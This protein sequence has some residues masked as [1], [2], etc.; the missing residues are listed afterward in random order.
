MS[1]NLIDLVTSTLGKQVMGQVGQILGEETKATESAIGAAIPAILGG[2]LKKASTPEGANDVFRSLDDEDGSILDNLGGLIGGGQHESLIEKGMVLLKMLFGSQQNSIIGAIAKAAGI[3]NSSAGSILGM[4]AP[5]VMG[6]LGKQRQSSGLDVGGLTDLLFSQKDHLA[7][8]MPK[9][10]TS[11]LGIANLLDSGADAVAGTVDSARR[12]AGRAASEAADTAQAAGGGL[13]KLLIPLLL[14]LGLAWL[15][16]KYFGPG[17]VDE[18]DLPTAEAGLQQLDAI[19]GDLT[20]TFDGLTESIQ[21]IT[22][23][24][25]ARSAVSKIEEATSTLDSLKLDSLPAAGATGLG[26]VLNPLIQKI[27]D[28]LETAYAIPGVRGVLEPA[29][30]PFLEK[31]EQLLPT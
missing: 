29:V 20:S 10:L 24:A 19:K 17:R 26:G 16:W 8:A 28:A 5:V 1:V 31:A 23:E 22:D 14:I 21:G 11:Q 30:A 7:G 3:G 15:G 4:L 18:G 13:M 27:K 9:D 6:V 2:L 12:T 25:S